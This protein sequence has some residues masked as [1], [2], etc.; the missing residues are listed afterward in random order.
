MSYQTPRKELGLQSNKHN[1]P[2]WQDAARR[3]PSRQP[4]FERDP[5]G[6]G[7]YGGRFGRPVAVPTRCQTPLELLWLPRY[8]H[9]AVRAC[10]W[11]E[12]QEGD[13]RL[14]QEAC[15]WPGDGRDGLRAWPWRDAHPVLGSIH[16]L[17]SAAM[18]RAH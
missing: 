14:W 9:A 12:G 10:W 8:E 18:V 1:M 13:N 16:P 2:K 3:A 4:T 6:A 17:R 5:G 11:W 7:T 15:G